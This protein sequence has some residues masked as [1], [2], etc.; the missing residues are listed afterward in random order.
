ML[1]TPSLL[2]SRLPS[3][4]PATLRRELGA[5]ADLVEDPRVTDI[6]VICDSSIY[7]DAG[8]G[9]TAVRGTRLTPAQATEL[10]RR[11]IEAGGR[12]LDEANP[13]A[14]VNL[15]HGLRVHAV[16]SPISTTG[17]VLSIRV[18]RHQRPALERLQ[19]A[20]HERV[21]PTLI[22]AVHNHQT[23]VVSGAT[24]SGKTTLLAALMAHVAPTERLVVLEDLAELSI[25]H[26]HVVSLECRAANIEG[27]G[28]IT[29][30]RLVREALRM[31]PS[32]LIVGECRGAEVADLLQAFLTGHRGGATTVHASSVSEVPVRLDALGA[33]ADLDPSQL[34]RQ[35]VS[36]IDLIVHVDKGPDQQRHITL[37]HLVI[38]PD[39]AL[40]VD[41]VA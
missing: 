5:L 39:G 2:W 6:F 36:A 24:G 1:E 23:L 28:E 35:A 11:L 22:R 29:L 15:G 14:D 4:P 17:P 32:R 19:I 27:A 21:L 34:A 18:H 33:M 40:G 38:T 8:E 41:P 10:A 7:V 37:G 30:A 3:R 26:P 9:A 13:L 12:H 20:H 16:L 25:D 31:K